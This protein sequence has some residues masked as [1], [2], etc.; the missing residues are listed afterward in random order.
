MPSISCGVSPIRDHAFFH[1]PQFQRLL[2]DNLFQRARFLP[3]DLHFV[4][5]RRS[6]RVARQAAFAGLQECPSS[7]DLRQKAG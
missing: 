1:Q 3:Q 7:N 6:G 2:S 4:A 5:A